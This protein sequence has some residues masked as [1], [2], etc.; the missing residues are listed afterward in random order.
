MNSEEESPPPDQEEGAELVMSEC[1]TDDVGPDR[2]GARAILTNFLLMA[3]LFSA[4]HGCTVSC[5]SLA[6]SRLGE[7]G[8][9]QSGALY[10][11]YTASAVLGA[12]YVTKELGA[13]NAITLGMG[14][15]C[16]YVGCFLV[17]TALPQVEKSAAIIG[18]SIGGVGAGFLWTAQGAY[19]ARSAKI[20]ARCLQQDV[21]ISTSY[22]A[23]FFAFFYLAEEVLVRLLSSALVDFV[24]WKTIFGIYTLIALVSTMGMIFVDNYPPDAG[25]GQATGGVFY[26]VT[27]AA[28]LL[29][30]D[31]KMK[32]MIGL[33]AA[34]GF[35]GAFLNSF[36][37]GEVVSAKY[38][39]VLA[40]WLAMVAAAMSVLFGRIKNKSLILILGSVCFCAAAVA[41]L[42][43]PNFKTIGTITIVLVYTLQGV[44]RATF[45]STLK[46]TFADFFPQEN[47]GAFANII[48]QN[49]LSSAIGYVLS[50]RLRCDTPSRYCVEFSD[51]T[52][53]NVLFFELLI[54]GTALFAIVGYLRAAAIFRSEQEAI[55]SSEEELL[56]NEHGVAT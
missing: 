15:Y 27:A 23:G 47:E 37:N 17:A 32:Y 36:V 38:V 19:F 31:P 5:L 29:V 35:S 50:F 51:G 14:L 12:T 1:E 24:S 54:C 39:G 16:I 42:V 9:W 43:H 2:N 40:G 21:S 7:V 11:T 20:H 6:T 8:A 56:E 28:F 49:G 13:R 44:G 30:R 45:E 25:S 4:N 52:L 18:A 53:H 34:F 33:N 22:L 46:A 26:K 3:I 41:F 48:L 55:P 10:L